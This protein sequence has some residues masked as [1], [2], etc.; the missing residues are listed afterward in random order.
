MKAW[1]L[2]ACIYLPLTSLG[3]SPLR[4]CLIFSIAKLKESEFDLVMKTLKEAFVEFVEPTPAGDRYFF[5]PPP[6]TEAFTPIESFTPQPLTQTAAVTPQRLMQTRD[7]PPSHQ[8]DISSS[9]I[10]ETPCKD[11]GTTKD[12]EFMNRRLGMTALTFLPM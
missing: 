3:S 8:D 1:V 4:V 2:K 5:T 9:I 11:L 7:T 10:P 6:L 12:S